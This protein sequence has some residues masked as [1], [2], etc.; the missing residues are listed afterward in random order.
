MACTCRSPPS[1]FDPG[2]AG[3]IITPYMLLYGLHDAL[4][5]AMPDNNQAPSLAE[6]VFRV[7]GRPHL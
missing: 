1:W 3:G 4:V 2:E 7:G 5:K 6:V